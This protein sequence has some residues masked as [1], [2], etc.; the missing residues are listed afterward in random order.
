M[1]SQMRSNFRVLSTSSNSQPKK[2]VTRKNV[3]DYTVCSSIYVLFFVNM[4]AYLHVLYCLQFT[5]VHDTLGLLDLWA[6][7]PNKPDHAS[8]T[9]SIEG[10]WKEHPGTLNAQFIVSRRDQYGD[11]LPEKPDSSYDWHKFVM[12]IVPD[13]GSSI[14]DVTT[15]DIDN[16]ANTF[17]KDMNT[18]SPMVPQKYTPPMFRLGENHTAKFDPDSPLD[19]FYI[20]VEVV[21][22]I[23]GLYPEMDIKE[24]VADDGIMRASFSGDDPSGKFLEA[25]TDL[26]KAREDVEDDSR[27]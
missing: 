7:K 10:Y 1:A 24:L 4:C 21:E 12:Q 19:T 13:E 18:L 20:D 25:H 27:D 26:L 16:I 15:K 9:G 3:I 23:Q 2:R 8:Y 5:K 17:V 22:I 6:H 11:P 14:K